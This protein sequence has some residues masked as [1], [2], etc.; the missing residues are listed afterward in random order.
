MAYLVSGKTVDTALRSA[1]RRNITALCASRSPEPVAGQ[2][3]PPLS[4]TNVPAPYHTPERHRTAATL[5][6]IPREYLRYPLPDDCQVLE[7]PD[8]R[9]L[10]YAEYGSK[11][12]DAHSFILIHGIPDTRLETGR[13]LHGNV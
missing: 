8:G 11:A 13:E 12:P 6:S 2:S 10:A 5:E 4:A 7:L 3:I 9:H 1:L